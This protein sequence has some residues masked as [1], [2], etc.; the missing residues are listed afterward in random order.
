MFQEK[1]EL[2][3]ESTLLQLPDFSRRMEGYLWKHRYY[4]VE[5]TKKIKIRQRY[6]VYDDK[7]G[8]LEF[9]TDANSPKIHKSVPLHEFQQIVEYGDHGFILQLR[10]LATHE[11]SGAKFVF[12]V[13]ENGIEKGLT[14]AE[15]RD[16]W[17]RLL[18]DKIDSKNNGLDLC[19]RA[20]QSI[21]HKYNILSRTPKCLLGKGLSGDVWKVSRKSDNKMFA[22]KTISLTNITRAQ[23]GALRREIDIMKSLDHP[24]IAKLQATYIEPKMNVRLIIDL[25]EGGELFRRLNR[26]GYFSERYAGKLL[27][28]MLK[29]LN[30]L[31]LNNIVHR[32]LKLENWLFRNKEVPGSDY[33]DADIALIDFGL[34][35][36]FRSKEEKI[37]KRVGTYYYMAP[38]V[39]AGEYYGSTCDMWSLGVIA[40]MLLSGRAPF[41]SAKDDD[42]EIIEKV[43]NAPIPNIMNPSEKDAI[44]RKISDQCKDF[45][46]CLLTREPEDRLTARQALDHPYIQQFLNLEPEED[47]SVKK[48]DTQCTHKVDDSTLECL[49]NFAKYKE[50]KRL[51]ME[52]IAFS[53]SHSEI[54]DLIGLFERIDN[55]HDGYIGL[56]ELAAALQD[57]DNIDQDE[58][59]EIFHALDEEHNGRVHVSEFVA[60]ALQAKYHLDENL[61]QEAFSRI[62]TGQK[63]NVTLDDLKNLLGRSGNQERIEEIWSQSGLANKSKTE[64]ISFEEFL[65]FM[66]T[67]GESQTQALRRGSGGQ[68]VV[69]KSELEALKER[70]KHKSSQRSLG[71]KKKTR[72]KGFFRKNKEGS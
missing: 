58:I 26:R 48:R 37:M 9:R 59:K 19:K 3:L 47:V 33:E 6:V 17:V 18:K 38:E 55:D 10:H 64:A 25:C 12:Q 51:T 34:S 57:H 69:E 27:T 40:F 46:L 36:Q 29:A 49:R 70:L 21:H 65:H 16:K 22:L 35:K 30:Y 14:Q 32:D 15:T 11:L 2:G 4:G 54:K 53:L 44:W 71:K 50:L 45:V 13:E 20:T 41:D 28:T 67:D 7:L 68:K 23:M 8:V 56:D 39:I 72:M 5:S 1:A 31:H 43:K 61:L 52:V 63:G 62:D 24:H 60:G 42:N 66:R